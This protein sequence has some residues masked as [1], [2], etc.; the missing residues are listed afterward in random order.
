MN[1]CGNEDRSSR[2]W[3]EQVIDS[4]LFVQQ[5]MGLHQYPEFI[6]KIMANFSVY[7]DAT[8]LRELTKSI[9]GEA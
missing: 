9:Q 7:L 4:I 3:L 2:Q 8:L 1:D 5:I 6:G